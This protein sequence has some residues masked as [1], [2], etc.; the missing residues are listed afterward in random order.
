LT[1]LSYF[2]R[3]TMRF[4]LQM[5]F[6]RFLLL[7]FFVCGINIFSVAQSDSIPHTIIADTTAKDTLPSTLFVAGISLYGNDKTKDF[8]IRR[9]I[10]FKE[11]D[12]LKAEKLVKDLEIAKQ[13]LINT[14][15]FLEVSVYIEN[16]YSQFVFITIYVKERWYILPLPYF[17]FID[18]NFNTWWV[19]YNH[20]LKR[21]NYGIKFLHNNISG[22]NDKFTAWLIT[23]Y[24]QQVA[25][26]YER[27]FFDRQLKNGFSVYAS[28]NNQREVNYATDSSKQQFFRPDS[29]FF[30]R[31][32]IK[33]EAN[34]IYRPG[35]RIKH[36]F[37]A[38]YI[39]EKI[40]DT[41]VALNHD[42]FANGE[43][44][45]SF[46]YIGY[47]FRY[48]NADYNLYPTR[49]F[50]SETTILHRG[51]TKDMNLTQLV[52]INSYT[53]PILPKTQI[54]IK[55]GAVLNLPFN[56]PFYN[57]SMFGYYG[58]IF[59]RGYEYYV[60]DGDAGIIGR[61]TLQHELFNY[62]VKPGLK[63]KRLVNYPIRF[64]GKLYTD[65]GY[66]Y[67][68]D[69][70]NSLLN[71]RLLHS[72]G[73]GVDIVMPYDIIFKLDYSFNQ[74]GGNGLFFHVSTDF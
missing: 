22:R 69:P 53:I 51:I 15:L 71:N 41:I 13:Q 27:P 29:L 7:I 73:L 30:V 67:D 49:G 66:A 74:L 8:I 55:E 37:R 1:G 34:Y 72:W 47:T 70:G 58:N 40:A 59:M 18:P 57:A 65:V 12:T 46:P 50:L 23:G 19:A 35:L 52:A 60:I 36:I 56:Q 31:R 44:K 43:K 64:F 33:V 38:G 42:Y 62:T 14:S 24:S 63:N 45:A 11:G 2:Y 48:T 16:R 20:S 61:A 17:K 3:I 10:P 68:K 39:Y 32:S 21:T 4:F 54:Q 5:K 6:F 9:E 26:K 25:L 28:Y